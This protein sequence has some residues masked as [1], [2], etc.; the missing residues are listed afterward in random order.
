MNKFEFI[1]NNIKKLK[2]LSTKGF[3]AT[4]S[5]SSIWT[6]FIYL[7]GGFDVAFKSLIIIVIIDYLT[8]VL[9]AIK[10]KKLNSK[11]SIWGIVKKLLYFVMVALAVIVDRITGTDGTIRNL[12][13]YFLIANDGI[14]ILENMGKMGVPIPKKLKDILE[15]LKEKGE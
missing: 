12:V 3:L 11:I 7:V 13:I 1:M 15:Q 8:G 9:N 14:S 4:I 6:S 2:T 5:L 10:K